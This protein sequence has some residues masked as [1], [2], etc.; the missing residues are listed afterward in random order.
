MSDQTA[1]DTTVRPPSA[2]RPTPDHS[3][4]SEPVRLETL[5]SGSH[6]IQFVYHGSSPSAA[7]DLTDLRSILIL[8]NIHLGHSEPD[9]DANQ[10]NVEFLAHINTGIDQVWG[11]LNALTTWS[12]ARPQYQLTLWQADATH[13]VARLSRDE[14]AVM[15]LR[16]SML[17]DTETLAIHI[18]D[19]IRE[20][21]KCRP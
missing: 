2:F 4:E 16:L 5:Q 11:F 13:K 15:T 18:S 7:G 10:A 14:Y 1:P 3:I 12:I 19:Q 9:H 20:T 8:R 21:T 6:P 17:D